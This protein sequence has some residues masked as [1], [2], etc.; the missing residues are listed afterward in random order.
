M[1]FVSKTNGDMPPTDR[2]EDRE[3]LDLAN[4]A[5]AK[6]LVLSA[7]LDLKTYEDLI[8]QRRTRKEQVGENCEKLSE[9]QIRKWLMKHGKKHLIN[10]DDK[11]RYKLKQFFKSL[12]EDGSGSIGTDELVDPLISLGIAQTREEVDK[13]VDSVDDDKSGQI[14]FKEFLQIIGGSSDDKGDTAIIDFF[15]DMISGRLAGGQISNKLPFHL[16]ISTVRRRKLINSMMGTNQ[17]DR[18]EGEKVMSAYAKLVSD[19][20]KDSSILQQPQDKSKNKSS[21]LKTQNS[22][23]QYSSTTSSF[24]SRRSS[25]HF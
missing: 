4:V 18:V 13:I 12:D 1:D 25:K 14:E 10:F 7:G 2:S 9:S 23:D 24:I 22:K 5:D 6:Q 21:K 3:K 11:E 15:K 16:I 17:K 8:E 20:K 19:R